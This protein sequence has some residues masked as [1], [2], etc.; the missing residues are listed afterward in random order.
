LTGMQPGGWGWFW[1]L[2]G[3]APPVEAAIPAVA[4]VCL[5]LCNSPPAVEPEAGKRWVYELTV[6]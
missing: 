1:R 3:G 4:G 6:E 2:G 5:H